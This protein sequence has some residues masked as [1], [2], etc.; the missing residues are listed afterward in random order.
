M[1][2]DFE[3]TKV[4]EYEGQSYATFDQAFEAAQRDRA[5]KLLNTMVTSKE[6]TLYWSSHVIYKN[7][8][9]LQ[10]LLQKINTQEHEDEQSKAA[11]GR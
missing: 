4:Y 6:G 11:Q 3:I 5:V 8:Y 1:P 10:D 9:A 7:R 2:E